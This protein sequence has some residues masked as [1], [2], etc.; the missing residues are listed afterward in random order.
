MDPALTILEF[1]IM[2]AVIDSSEQGHSKLED[3]QNKAEYD[4]GISARKTT[5]S[6]KRLANTGCIV[7]FAGNIF[8]TSICGITKYEK[9][10]LKYVKKNI[11]RNKEMQRNSL[12]LHMFNDETTVD[13][14]L[15]SGKHSIK[16]HR[17]VLE[18]HC[19]ELRRKI[20]HSRN[21]ELKLR[22]RVSSEILHIIKGAIY[23]QSI[24]ITKNILFDAYICGEELN[25]QDFIEFSS[26]FIKMNTDEV[27]LV[28]TMNV[29]DV[30]QDKELE[31]ILI[32]FFRKYAETFL[33]DEDFLRMLT[34]QTTIKLLLQGLI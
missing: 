2:G 25:M 14:V 16:V 23:Y 19:E 28:Q 4:H 24:H 31:A 15:R 22:C 18:H 9:T 26:T 3:I 27:N 1:Q 10:K 6:L 30:E 12:L 17:T 7:P 33:E 8:K 20:S 21:E 29:L 5:Q 34:N 11:V 32:C 13:F